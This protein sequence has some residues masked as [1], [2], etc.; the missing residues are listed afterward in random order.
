MKKNVKTF[1]IEYNRS[2]ALHELD[3]NAQQYRQS[4]IH[5]PKKKIVLNIQ[6]E[7]KNVG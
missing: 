6:V 5:F 4:S 3:I 7:K 1:P 2:I